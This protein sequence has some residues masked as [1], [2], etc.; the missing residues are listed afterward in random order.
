MLAT[1]TFNSQYQPTN[2]NEVRLPALRLLEGGKFHADQFAPVLIKEYE[3]LRLKF[4]R[5]G[6]IPAWSKPS[7]PTKG[8]PYAAADHLFNHTVYQIPVRRQR[9]LIPADGYYVE[10]ASIPS[11]QTF[12]LARPDEAT[13]CFAGIYD[14]SR[15]KDGSTLHTFSIVTTPSNGEMTRFGLQMPLVLPKKYEALWLN[16]NAN[17]R[18]ISDLLYTS[19]NHEL[20]IHPVRELQLHE[21]E[22]FEQVAA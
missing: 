12:K 22:R 18:R 10:A 17:L 7:R 19:A 5:W 15:Q 11:K 21:M 16:P 2:L 20:S 8:R 9:C 4:F 14:S 13:F 3:Q 1:Y 6:L